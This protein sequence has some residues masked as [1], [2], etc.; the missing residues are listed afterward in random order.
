MK[1]SWL[2]NQL[3][4]NPKWFNPLYFHLRHYVDVPTI[5]KIKVYGGKSAAKTFT[6]AQLFS[7]LAYSKSESAICYRKE[8]T[9]IKTTLKES[10]EKAIE[11]LYFKK[12]TRV[13]DFRI[14]GGRG[15]NIVFKGMDNE[16]KVKGIEGFKYLLFDEL[17][18]FEQKEWEQA[19]LT[20][21]GI[22]GA[23]LFAT[24][25]PIDE[26]LWIKKEL[27]E[28][29]WVDL[30]LQIGDNPLSKLDD[31]SSVQISED[32]K[33]LLIRTTYLD[34]KWVTGAEGYGERDENLIHEYEA[35][36]KHN[37]NRYRVNVL[38]LWGFYKT[39]MEFFPPFNDSH[40]DAT[41][42]YDPSLP[43]HITY[44]FNVNPYM[45]L[46]VAQIK[47]QDKVAEVRWIDEFCFKHPW[48]T[49]KAVTNKFYTKYFEELKHNSGLFYYGDASGKQRSTREVDQAIKHDYDVVRSVLKRVLNA[50]SDRTAK[51]NPPRLARRD[52]IIDSLEGSINIVNK[53]SPKCVELIRDLRYLK[54]DADGFKWKQEVVDAITGQKYQKHG[55]TSD[56]ME[57]LECRAFSNTFK[58]YEKLR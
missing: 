19:N 26:D 35:L 50:G 7:V 25:N 58:R 54:Q 48:N 45:T 33:I 41:M 47:I 40:I 29:K 22:V 32:G 44:D 1:K 31:N 8:Q 21:R 10:F 39:G 49:T 37:D 46:L 12:V 52:F 38:G 53:F 16:G 43:L 14:E 2:M 30:P 4:L 15:G 42:Q 9:T 23:K 24:W 5:R 20:L 11:K 17:D 51:R 28:H 13:L 27:D 36:K 57:Y 55:H 6:I 3:L 56:A 34:N 18:H